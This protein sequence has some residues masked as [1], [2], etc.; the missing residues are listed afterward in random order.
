MT[1]GLMRRAAII[2]ALIAAL[3]AVTA[4]AASAA[5]ASHPQRRQFAVTTSSDFRVVLTATRKGGH[6]LMAT[7]TAAGYQRSGSDWK[8]IAAK[9]IGKAGGWFWRSV[10]T[11]SLT[12]AQFKNTKTGSPPEEAF[13]SAKVSLLMTPATGCSPTY[14]EH[15]KP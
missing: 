14:R 4:V 10:N 1:L 6:S 2:A 15:W 3:G 5:G 8:L 7:V 12:V 9:R 13:D 11:C